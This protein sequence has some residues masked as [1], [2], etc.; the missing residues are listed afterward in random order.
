[1]YEHVPIA[2][3]KTS[4]YYGTYRGAYLVTSILFALY[5]FSD[6]HHELKRWSRSLAFPSNRFTKGYN[7]PIL[8]WEYF[9]NFKTLVILC[10]YIGTYVNIRLH[11]SCTR[12]RITV[13]RLFRRRTLRTV[14]SVPVFLSLFIFIRDD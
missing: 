10:M 1:M 5:Y 6:A 14:F 9:R 3:T 2:I 8:S 7:T 13:T 11:I 4:W 12:V